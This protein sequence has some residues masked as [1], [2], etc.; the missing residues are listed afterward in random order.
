MRAT[1][2]PLCLLLA[3]CG[4]TG[5]GI[6]TTTQREVGA[7]KKISVDSA[8]DA[9]VHR[10]ARAVSLRT[11]ENY[12]DL[13]EVLVEGETLIIRSRG[14]VLTP[15]VLQ[16]DITNDV[17]EGVEAA[18]AS[19]VSGAATAVTGFSARASGASS[20]TVTDLSSTDLTLSATGA[21]TVTVS[22]A[23]T[24]G[25]IGAE[26]ASSVDA[27]GV[28]LNTLSVDVSGASTVKARV[29][30]TLEGAVSGA[31]QLTITGTP[32]ARVTESGASTVTLG[33]P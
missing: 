17:F 4:G 22:G 20:I 6:L 15:T 3:A 5:N 19:R 11:D 2:F 1:I 21:S 26:G 30:T 25:T 28:P 32:T 12:Q 27:R 7:F 33:A 31:S 29:S 8:V 9:Q 23:A 24:S 16:A 10:G 14:A 13:V 18:G